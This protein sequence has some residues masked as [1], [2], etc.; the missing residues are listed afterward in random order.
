MEPMTGLELPSAAIHPGTSRRRNVPLSS[1]ASGA[2][3]HLRASGYTA[4]QRDATNGVAWFVAWAV[5]LHGR[6]VPL[7]AWQFLAGGRTWARPGG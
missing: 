6:C 4:M 5:Y 2:D 3:Q 7:K 1:G